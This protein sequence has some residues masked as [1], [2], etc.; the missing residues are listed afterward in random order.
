MYWIKL[1]KKQMA[2]NS[3]DAIILC[4]GKG[5]RLR[6]VV[7]D[8]PKPMALIHD[9][10]FLDILIDYLITYSMGKIIL[11]TGFKSQ[12]IRDYYENERKIPNLVF[13]DEDIPLG[14]AGAL[15]KAC[16]LVSSDLILVL[17][18][19]SF[20]E[21]DLK[22][23]INFHKFKKASISLVLSKV[24]SSLNQN[25]AGN[26][27]FGTVLINENSEIQSFKEKVSTEGVVYVNSGVYLIQRKLLSLIPD[28]VKFSLEYDFFPDLINNSFYGYVT[29]QSFIDIGTK[30]RFQN[31]LKMLKRN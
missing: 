29:N 17:N 21:V 8:R 31:A 27:N 6:S 30:E 4:G 19:D 18:G 2:L 24:D 22:D 15:R 3:I 28:N 20:C 7:N 25:A 16:K 26:F 11:S 13:S 14:T 1:M 10:P 12:F 9:R 23:L 5:T